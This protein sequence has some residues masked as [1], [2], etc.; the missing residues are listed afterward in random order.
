MLRPHPPLSLITISFA[1]PWR[2]GPTETSHVLQ[3]ELLVV[4]TVVVVADGSLALRLPWH[5]HLHLVQPHSA[6]YR[7]HCRRRRLW[8]YR[9]TLFG[10]L[11]SCNVCGK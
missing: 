4:V 7:P 1:L 11:A 9:L 5:L 8:S 3:F 10:L 2:A 6:I